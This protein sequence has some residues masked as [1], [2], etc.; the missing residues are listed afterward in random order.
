MYSPAYGY[1]NPAGQP[2]NGA[3]QGQNPQMQPGPGSNQPHQSMMYNQQQYPMG[4]GGGAFSGA[5]NPGA[6]MPGSAGPAGMMQNTAL[7]QMP[8]N[9][10]SMS[11]FPICLYLR[12]T[13]R[14][15]FTCLVGTSPLLVLLQDLLLVRCP[16][17]TSDD[18]TVM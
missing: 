3:P 7:P 1:G 11:T 18:L 15:V 16:S 12:V 8:A 2:Y 5:P 6:M 4:P 10:Q 14:E 9:S 17:S 13:P